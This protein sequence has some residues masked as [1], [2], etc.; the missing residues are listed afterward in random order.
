MQF[1]KIIDG[2][3]T[4]NLKLDKYS[5][6]ELCN[7]LEEEPKFK[8]ICSL[9]GDRLEYE[10]EAIMPY[11]SHFDDS[12][13]RVLMVF[14][15]PA[16]N[17]VKNGM[18]YFSKKP[19][20]KPPGKNYTY[21]KHQMWSKLEKAELIGHV[22]TNRIDSFQTRQEEANIRKSLILEGKT[23]DKFQIGLTT[24]YSFPT[25]VVGKFKNV[26]GIKKVFVK[27]T[28]NRINHEEI[29]RI[30]EYPFSKRAIFIFVQKT[31]YEIFKE[32]ASCDNQYYY[33][34]GVAMMKRGGSGADLKNLLDTIF[35]PS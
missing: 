19:K 12:K 3:Y 23:A 30:L 25:P 4:V 33:W 2:K 8:D 9:N 31:T 21:D 22:N 20:L 11:D 7:I 16:I 1:S 32:N 15:N 28:L 13:S 5:A 18:F 24:L 34:P 10:S 17:S 35:N 6:S 29:K 27:K 26:A 14:G